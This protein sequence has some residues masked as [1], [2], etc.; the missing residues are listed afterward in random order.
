M[1]LRRLFAF[2]QQI[3]D[4]RAYCSDRGSP[5]RARAVVVRNLIGCSIKIQQRP[6][7]MISI[8]IRIRGFPCQQG[9]F[10]VNAPAVTGSRSCRH[11]LQ[12]RP[13]PLL[14]CGALDIQRQI[15]SDPGR[16][17]RSMDFQSR[18]AEPLSKKAARLTSRGFSYTEVNL[19][20]PRRQGTIS[21]HVYPLPTSCALP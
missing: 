9:L 21:R 15:E 20:G 11:L 10:P 3:S 5:T 7:R 19:S 2:S 12:L 18:K 14:K 8:S 16:F 17:S 13:V 6:K 1:A 4:R